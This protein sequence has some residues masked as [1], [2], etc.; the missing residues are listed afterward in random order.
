MVYSAY[1]RRTKQKMIINPMKIQILTGIAYNGG[2]S[3]LL[4]TLDVICD[5]ENVIGGN[6]GVGDGTYEDGDTEGTYEDGVWNGDE[7]GD[8]EGDNEGDWEGDED[9]DWDG[10]NAVGWLVVPLSKDGASDGDRDGVGLMMNH[11]CPYICPVHGY[12]LTYS[13]RLICRLLRT[14]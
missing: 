10:E 9:G 1:L 14:G 11:C 4:D 3:I 12:N 7:D 6:V 8:C 5:G 2:A 13:P